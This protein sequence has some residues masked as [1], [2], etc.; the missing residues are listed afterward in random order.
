MADAH[1]RLPKHLALAEGIDLQNPLTMVADF[2]GRYNPS[3]WLPMVAYTSGWLLF[4]IKLNGYGTEEK[5]SP[6]E[7]VRK[8]H[9][10]N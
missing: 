1:F 7:A 8:T 6:D 4:S 9:S 5:R 10:F 2:T 3:L